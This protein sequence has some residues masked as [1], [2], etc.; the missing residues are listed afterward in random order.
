ML[1]TLSVLCVHILAV[2][3]TSSIHKDI[4]IDSLDTTWKLKAPISNGDFINSGTPGGIPLSFDCAVRRYA[5]EYGKQIQPRHGHFVELFDAL[6]LAACNV[7]RPSAKKRFPPKYKTN[8][9]SSC[10]YYIDV[11]SGSD[12]NDGSLS[13]PFQSILKGIETTRSRRKTTPNAA[14]VLQLME[15]TYYQSQTIE[16]TSTDSSLTIQNYNGQKVTISGGVPLQ[17]DAPWKLDTYEETQW[18]AYADW[19]NVYGIVREASSNDQTKYL[20]VVTSYDNCLKAAETSTMNPFYSI[21]WNS[22]S[23]HCYGMKDTH[24]APVQQSGMISGHLEGRN[25][26]SVS[27]KN[28]NDLLD[29]KIYGWRVN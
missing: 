14:C 20:G 24:W 22:T 23:L 10:T 7:T 28:T 16:L 8:T 26:W 5:W 29:G 15:G 3:G 11:N 27:V 25:I 6:Q 21:T 9:A 1:A 4:D 2:Y 13:S 19:S 18:V 17:F 12:T